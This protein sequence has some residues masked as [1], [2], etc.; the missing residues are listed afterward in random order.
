VG[1]IS[2]RAAPGRGAPS[3]PQVAAIRVGVDRTMTQPKSLYSARIGAIGVMG[4]PTVGPPVLVVEQW[5]PRQQCARLPGGIGRPGRRRSPA[6]PFTV[7]SKSAGP[8]SGT[9]GHHLGNKSMCWPL[10]PSCLRLVEAGQARTSRPYM[11]PVS[12][13]IRTSPRPSGGFVGQ[14]GKIGPAPTPPGRPDRMSC[15]GGGRPV[16]P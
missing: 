11:P 9:L 10:P 1:K 15:N 7:K 5:R 4:A 6:R 8:T 3:P 2:A 14:A 12:Y 16:W 13:H